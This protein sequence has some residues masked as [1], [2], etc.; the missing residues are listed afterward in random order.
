MC[1]E[2]A[3]DM[4]SSGRGRHRWLA[5]VTLAVTAAAVLLLPA[6]A[7]DATFA[8]A[9]PTGGVKVARSASPATVSVTDTRTQSPL[10]VVVTITGTTFTIAPT[11]SSVTLATASWCLKARNAAR[12]ETGTG[13][14]GAATI[15]NQNG[16]TKPIAY[17][18]VYSVTS[19]ATTPP[20]CWTSG[21]SVADGRLTGAI[22]TFHNFTLY[23]ASTDGTCSRDSAP[24]NTIVEATDQAGATAVCGPIIK[25]AL[26]N[27]VGT[28]S[29]VNDAYPAAPGS[30]WFCA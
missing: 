19:T 26:G 6:G 24:I 28:P 12:I 9:C 23:P 7:A 17:V 11:D 15:K 2:G 8:K 3:S 18:V 16:V 14:S 10:S 21:T 13:T 30:Y 20:P 22:N 27:Y 5:S 29:R 25:A 4:Y 1:G